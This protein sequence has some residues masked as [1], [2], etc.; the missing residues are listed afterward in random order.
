[1]AIDTQTGEDEARVR[2][3]ISES[4]FGPCGFEGELSGI[5]EPTSL[6]EFFRRKL[7][8]RVAVVRVFQTTLRDEDLPFVPLLWL[9]LFPRSKG[10]DLESDF[11]VVRKRTFP[12]VA[13]GYEA[14]AVI[15]KPLVMEHM[16]DF[17]RGSVVLLGG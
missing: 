6:P 8:V 4:P 3:D 11:K 2:V 12:V 7:E 1:M 14:G 13:Y 9:I 17:G 10:Q 5:L 15:E 16:H